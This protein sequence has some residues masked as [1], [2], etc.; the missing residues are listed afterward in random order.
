MVIDVSHHNGKINWSKVAKTVDSV[1]IK[2]TEGSNY[3]DPMLIKNAVGGDTNGIKVGYY[4]F[5]TLN[6]QDVVIDAINEAEWF[7]SNI[8]KAVAPSLPLVLDIETNKLKISRPKVLAYI[9]AF[10]RQLKLS[11]YEDYMLYSYTSFLN[12]NLP[13]QHPLGAIRLWLADYNGSYVI[14]KGWKE[15]YL[16][17]YTDKGK[18]DGIKGNVDINRYVKSPQ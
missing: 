9:Q 1:F 18:V 15:I 14:P 16:H 13:S 7:M 12:E 3:V 2:A 4:H 17:Q 11:G 5:A 8:K 10:F 6:S